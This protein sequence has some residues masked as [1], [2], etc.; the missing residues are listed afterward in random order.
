MTE[1]DP[2]LEWLGIRPEERPLTYYRLLGISDFESDP[3]VIEMAVR[4][5]AEKLRSVLTGDKQQTAQA[6]IK[7]IAKAKTCLL[8]VQQKEL[9]D[10]KL[11]SAVQPAQPSVEPQKKFEVNLLSDEAR[12]VSTSRWMMMPAIVAV[13]TVI[14]VVVSLMQPEAGKSVSDISGDTGTTDGDTGTPDDDPKTPDDDPIAYTKPV[15]WIKRVI[16]PLSE[17]DVAVTRLK[18][19]FQDDLEKAQVEGPLAQ[20]ALADRIF[21]LSNDYVLT[22]PDIDWAELFAVLQFSYLMARDS[23]SKLQTD[24]IRDRLDEIFSVDLLFLGLGE[25]QAWEELVSRN[26]MAPHHAGFVDLTGPPSY[27]LS[28]DQFVM[29]YTLPIL[30]EGVAF[31]AESQQRYD[32]A[33]QAYEGLIRLQRT[34]TGRAAGGIVDIQLEKILTELKDQV[35][36]WETGQARAVVSRQ[37]FLE[38]QKA[39]ESVK[40]NPEDPAANFAAGVYLALTRGD[41]DQG[42]RHLAKGTDDRLKR[43]AEAEIARLNPVVPN[44]VSDLQ[45]LGNDWADYGQQEAK[46]VDRQTVY[47]HAGSWY[48]RAGK[49]ASSPL[50]KIELKKAIAALGELDVNIAVDPVADGGK[51]FD[52]IILD[53]KKSVHSWNVAIPAGLTA[54]VCSLEFT[55]LQ[56]FPGETKI[57]KQMVAAGGEILILLNDPARIKFR[58]RFEVGKDGLAKITLRCNGR[59]VTGGN[60]PLDLVRVEK[61]KR[62]QMTAITNATV[63]R[64]KHQKALPELKRIAEQNRGKVGAQLAVTNYNTCLKKINITLPQIIKNGN[65][66]IERFDEIDQLLKT[67]DGTAEIHFKIVPTP[68]ANN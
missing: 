55:K 23:G 12:K 43:L 67:L 52:R 36:R 38:Y 18:S 56:V 37:R 33:A 6:I 42:C 19:A 28:Y 47:N 26:P 29:G 66:K 27:M 30:Y 10:K 17:W 9:Y 59:L 32:L 5:R 60:I 20:A 34:V 61:A 50:D 22:D 48:E 24:I 46:P 4:K 13:V 8:N 25:C 49:L 40:Q 53:T 35:A 57:P 64:E 31:Q 2:Y 21:Q 1:F 15:N 41:W 54:Q 39:L 11:R 14:I 58:V 51:I 44:S 7:N 16:P 45:S 62:A 63:T 65:L 68:S 3:A